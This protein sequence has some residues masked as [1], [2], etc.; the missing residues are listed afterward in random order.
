M[1]N[2]YIMFAHNLDICFIQ[3]NT[4]IGY[5]AGSEESFVSG[6]SCDA[7]VVIRDVLGRVVVTGFVFYRFLWRS[8]VVDSLIGCLSSRRITLFL[9]SLA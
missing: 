3:V 2:F 1:N 6:L 5:E 9:V 4:V 7:R 8:N